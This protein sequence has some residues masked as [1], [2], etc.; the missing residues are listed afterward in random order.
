MTS[1][2]RAVEAFELWWISRP[3]ANVPEPF[4]CGIPEEDAAAIWLNAW[5]SHDKHQPS[6]VS[7]G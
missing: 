2:Q 5:R 1:D 6:G 4:K 3:A 7:H